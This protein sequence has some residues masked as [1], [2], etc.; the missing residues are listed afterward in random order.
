MEKGEALLSNSN[1]NKFT[2]LENIYKLSSSVLPCLLTE[3]FHCYQENKQSICTR[4]TL[5]PS[6]I[7]YI[8]ISNTFDTPTL[9]KKKKKSN[10]F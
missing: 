2:I 7:T 6:S 4:H 3:S 8:P 9:K 1:K 10:T 5:S